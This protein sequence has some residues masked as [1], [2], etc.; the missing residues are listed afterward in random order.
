MISNLHEELLNQLRKKKK[1]EKLI[2]YF[3][4]LRISHFASSEQLACRPAADQARSTAELG[5]RC[6]R[7]PAFQRAAQVRRRVRLRAG[8]R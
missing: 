4:L 2:F 5:Q 6:R 3:S 1:K 7:R 8:E